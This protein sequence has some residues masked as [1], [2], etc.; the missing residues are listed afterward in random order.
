MNLLVK[1]VG[2]LEDGVTGQ[3]ART[4][5]EYYHHGVQQ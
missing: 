4:C 2:A 1:V 5:W 3:P